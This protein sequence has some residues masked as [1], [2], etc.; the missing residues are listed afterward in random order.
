MLAG[1][2][3]SGAIRQA[4]LNSQI[5]LTRKILALQNQELDITEH[6]LSAGGIADS[7]VRNQRMVIAQT[8]AAI[9]PLQQRLS[10]VNDELA[11]LMGEAPAE[12]RITTFSLDSFHLPREL[13]FSLPS[14]LVQQRPDVR[15]AESLLREAS[16]NVGV[17]SANLYPQITLS[18]GGGGT[19]TSFLNG[20]DIWNVG[21]ALAQP[22]FDGGALRAEKRKAQAAYEEADSLY[23]QTVLEA[24]QQVADTLASIENDALAL[25]SRNE[26][27]AE[28]DASY[29]IATQRLQA[30]GISAAG[31]LVAQQQQLQT[32][33]D[34]TTEVGARYADTATLFQALGGGWWNDTQYSAPR[35]KN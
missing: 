31:L 27:A 14:S 20:G 10:E 16:A 26:A 13:P 30:G 28:A 6:R 25:K 18:G 34:R 29:E 3:V 4:Q 5:D 19:G 35:P 8:E 24:F 7:E 32:A 33:M 2:V 1:N 11:V 15:S 22:I 12:A 21:G 17:A 9:P 23:K